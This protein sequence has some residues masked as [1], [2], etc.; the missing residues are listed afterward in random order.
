MCVCV[1]VCVCIQVGAE[2]Y[3]RP[4]EMRSKLAPESQHTL[5]N[6][7]FSVQHP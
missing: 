2:R 6:I 5:I 3:S 7:S 4:G 1:C